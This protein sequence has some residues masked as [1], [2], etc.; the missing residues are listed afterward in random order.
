MTHFSHLLLQIKTKDLQ[1][2]RIATSCF[3]IF[4]INLLLQASTFQLKMYQRFILKIQEIKE[5]HKFNVKCTSRLNNE[6]KQQ[7]KIKLRTFLPSRILKIPQVV[8]YRQNTSINKLS[9]IHPF[10]WTSN[11]Y[12]KAQKR[13]KQ[14]LVFYF[15]EAQHQQYHHHHHHFISLPLP[16]L[17]LSIKLSTCKDTYNLFYECK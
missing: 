16:S 6:S 15:Y 13:F 5:K 3:L 4:R 12:E 7:S 10:I 17:Y 9:L 1:S 2:G 11:S 8:F 14:E